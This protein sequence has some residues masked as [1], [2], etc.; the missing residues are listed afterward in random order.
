MNTTHT[1]FKDLD[2]WKKARELR[3][4]ISDLITQFPDKE[5]FRLTDQIVRASRSVT[6]NIAE[7]SGRFYYKENIQ[8]CRQAR[9]SLYELN[10]HIICAYDEG[11]I[12]EPTLQMIDAKIIYCLKLLNG[13]IGYLKKAGK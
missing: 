12:D 3:M 5:K 2:V 1:N 13:Y 6:A 4:D 10:D 7:G 8:F 9:G 11:Y